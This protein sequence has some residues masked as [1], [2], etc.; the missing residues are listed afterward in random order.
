MYHSKQP[1]EE[2]WRWARW[3]GLRE[4]EGPRLTF[5]AV[6]AS[7][8]QLAHSEVPC[9]VQ[10]LCSPQATFLEGFL[11]ESAVAEMTLGELSS[12][13]ASLNSTL[14]GDVRLLR[15]KEAMILSEGSWGPVPST[16]L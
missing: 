3:S 7:R 11:E 14:G 9:P 5:L 10:T 13:P 6:A 8:L 16:A 4:R 1:L 12:S 2:E 15:V